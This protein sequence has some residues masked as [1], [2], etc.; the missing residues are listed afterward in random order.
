MAGEP[1]VR[2]QD[3]L[4]LPEWVLVFP[5]VGWA[6][7]RAHEEIDFTHWAFFRGAS[8]ANGGSGLIDLCSAARLLAQARGMTQRSARRA[9]A[10]GAERGYW[11]IEP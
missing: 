2:N 3:R 6:A 4:T 11:S 9:I 10:R 1:R 7:L 8:V 5:A